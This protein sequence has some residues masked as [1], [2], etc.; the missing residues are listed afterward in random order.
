MKLLKKLNLLNGKPIHLNEQDLE[1]FRLALKGMI[2]RVELLQDVVNGCEDVKGDEMLSL[3]RDDMT[4]KL[5][6]S[7]TALKTLTSLSKRINKL[8]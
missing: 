6:E 3:Y 7:V 2:E 1:G 4:K 5:Q 8:K